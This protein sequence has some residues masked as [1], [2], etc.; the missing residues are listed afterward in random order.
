MFFFVYTF[1]RLITTYALHTRQRRHKSI[2]I[3]L[4]INQSINQSIH[5]SVFIKT[6]G[7]TNITNNKFIGCVSAKHVQFSQF[8]CSI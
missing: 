3:I 4:S 2:P 5:P 1:I 6:K 8:N 7:G